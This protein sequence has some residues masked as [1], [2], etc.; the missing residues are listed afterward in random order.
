MLIKELYCY[1]NPFNTLAQKL[2]SLTERRNGG[3]SI[4]LK[5]NEGGGSFYE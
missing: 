5:I 1:W 2:I 3:G 4:Y